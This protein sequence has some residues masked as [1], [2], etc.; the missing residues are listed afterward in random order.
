ML[1]KMQLKLFTAISEIQDKFTAAI[2][3]FCMGNKIG[4]ALW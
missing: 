4:M 1:I 3:T 2:E